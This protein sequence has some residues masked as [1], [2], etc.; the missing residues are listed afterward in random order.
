MS[1]EKEIKEKLKDW[2]EDFDLLPLDL[3]LEE[4]KIERIKS[5]IRQLLAQEKAKWVK[6]LEKLY[7]ETGGDMD[8]VFQELQQRIKKV[9]QKPNIE[10]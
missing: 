8:Y 3:N 5:F 2:E 7:K 10:I 4:K 6:E 9:G 1:K